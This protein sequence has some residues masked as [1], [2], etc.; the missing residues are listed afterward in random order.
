MPEVKLQKLI[1][2]VNRS[3]GI[4]AS[5]KAL[6]L[7]IPERIRTAVVAA[8]TEDENADEASIAAANAA[9]DGVVADL[10]AST[11]DLGAAIA[12]NS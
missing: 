2:E 5:A 9:I 7:G 3:K 1:D 6:I 12:S 4:T 11:D 8:L 10:A